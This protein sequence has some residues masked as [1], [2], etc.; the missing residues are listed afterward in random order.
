MKILAD[1]N[2]G[3]SFRSALANAGHDVRLIRDI[4][5]GLD[6]DAVFALAIEQGCVLLTHDRDFGNISERADARP[7][8]IV[9]MRL[10]ALNAATR[11]A[12]VVRVLAELGENLIGHFVVVEP[13]QVRSRPF[14]IDG[15]FDAL[16][17]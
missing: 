7:P 15:E 5:P 2:C 10:R 1:E 6:D 8:A 3:L 11:A 17:P 14:K 13:H 16:D 9:L 12:M 4:S